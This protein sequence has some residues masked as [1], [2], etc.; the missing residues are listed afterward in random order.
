MQHSCFL[1]QDDRYP[2]YHTNRYDNQFVWVFFNVYI[3]IKVK[4][5]KQLQACKPASCL[6]IYVGHEMNTRSPVMYMTAI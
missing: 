3:Y 6:G 1:K 5:N 2:I 4:Y